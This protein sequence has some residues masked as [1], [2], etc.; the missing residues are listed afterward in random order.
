[1]N[2]TL[3]KC[4]C[5]LYCNYILCLKPAT[6]INKECN[7]D[8][9]TIYYYLRKFKISIRSNSESKR[10]K[11]NPMYGTHYPNPRKIKG[12]INNRDWLY[13]EYIIKNK[14]QT[15]IA[16]ENNTSKCT[17]NRRLKD[18]KIPIKDFSDTVLSG[19]DHPFFGK[20]HKE[21]SKKKMSLAHRTEKYPKY[22]TVH[23]IIN[24]IKVKPEKCEICGK[25]YDIYGSSKLQLSNISGDLNLDP[26]NFQY[27]HCS[28]H[29]NYDYTNE[30]I[31]ERR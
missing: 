21:I 15:K 22:I 3:Y 19:Q 9:S 6:E 24:E 12:K 8:Y 18:L 14:S 25:K 10:G 27:A 16:E 7:C 26:N 29:R 11:L 13:E 17:I 5:Y 2:E 20:Q 28:C 30:I 1:M 31:H 23:K 4:P